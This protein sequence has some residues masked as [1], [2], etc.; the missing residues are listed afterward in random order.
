MDYQG[1]SIITV[2]NNSLD[3]WPNIEIQCYRDGQ[4]VKDIV[5]FDGQ[6]CWVKAPLLE[7][8]EENSTIH[9]VVDKELNYLDLAVICLNYEAGSTR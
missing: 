1:Y 3:P 5:L 9:F 6:G 8:H 4:D 7:R 2:L